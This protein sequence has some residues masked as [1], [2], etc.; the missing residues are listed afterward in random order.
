MTILLSLSHEEAQR[1]RSI[2]QDA[3]EPTLLQKI[4]EE[5]QRLQEL[6]DFLAKSASRDLSLDDLSLD[7][8]IKELPSDLKTAL[9]ALQ[10]AEPD[11]GISDY[12]H[13][14][15]TRQRGVQS[16]K[17]RTKKGAVGMLE[18]LAAEYGLDGYN[19]PRK[20]DKKT[21]PVKLQ[22][23]YGTHTQAVSTSARQQ[24]GEPYRGVQNVKR[25]SIQMKRQHIRGLVALLILAL[26]V[27][28][29]GLTPLAASTPEA[30]AYEWLVFLFMADRPALLKTCTTNYANEL[31]S[32]ITD[33]DL[34]HLT[35]YIGTMTYTLATNLVAH[36]LDFHVYAISDNT[37]FVRCSNKIGSSDINIIFSFIVVR[38]YE[39]WKVG[40]FLY[41]DH[42]PYYRPVQPIDPNTL[43]V[44]QDE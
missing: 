5:L 39:E 26:L 11:G 17:R 43:L 19:G 28:V 6:D 31:E 30:A 15:K 25:R 2:L 23:D 42:R 41:D 40:L 4:E 13:V 1:L 8:V 29:F 18:Q 9:E 35:E 12:K 44:M 34:K 27:V 38:E 33:T 36:L 3:N 16:A 20:L 24:T 10:Q 22:C 37:A 21:E 32:I 7:A 14:S